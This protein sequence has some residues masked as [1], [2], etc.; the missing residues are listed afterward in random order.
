MLCLAFVEMFKCQRREHLLIYYSFGDIC[1]MLFLLGL[2]ACL[3]ILC[4]VLWNTALFHCIHTYSEFFDKLQIIFDQVP[5]KSY[6]WNIVSFGGQQ[7]FTNAL[8][9]EQIIVKLGSSRPLTQG[10]CKSDLD[11]DIHNLFLF[12]CGTSLPGHD[13]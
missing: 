3:L 6:D 4:C 13:D 9:I 10:K 8:S 5:W 1:S 2:L 11:S 12:G 7:L